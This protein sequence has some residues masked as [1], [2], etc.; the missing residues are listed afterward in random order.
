MYVLS[1]A[2]LSIYKVSWTCVFVTRVFV[3]RKC[4]YVSQPKKEARKAYL[5]TLFSSCN[6][7]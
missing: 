7:Y 1:I 6:Y 3:T 2:Y 4:L 5:V